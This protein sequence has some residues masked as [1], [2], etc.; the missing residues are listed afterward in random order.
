MKLNFSERALL[1]VYF[2]P[3]ISEQSRL[4]GALVPVFMRLLKYLRH[5]S[6]SVHQYICSNA[7][8]RLF[9][10]MQTYYKKKER[11]AFQYLA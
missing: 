7:T 9:I 1:Y 8:I 5:F 11:V 10:H 4:I 3:E 6:I 2:A